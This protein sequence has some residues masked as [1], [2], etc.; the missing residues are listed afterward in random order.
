M[1]FMCSVVG[2]NGNDKEPL[3]SLEYEIPSIKKDSGN[4]K[5]YIPT[6]ISK[7]IEEILKTPIPEQ[8]DK[9][10]SE[11]L[12]FTT[13]CPGLVVSFDLKGRMR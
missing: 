13:S 1:K 8:L 2:Q 10:K 4:L 7:T 9:Y 3:Y 11:D 6:V 5:R 12:V